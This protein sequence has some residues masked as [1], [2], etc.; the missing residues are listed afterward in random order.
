MWNLKKNNKKK[1][2][3][4]NVTKKK[5]K[6]NRLIDTEDK[7]V[8]IHGERGRERSNIGVSY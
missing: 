3:L 1:P 8:V 5:E 2:K 6:R 4:V 7:L